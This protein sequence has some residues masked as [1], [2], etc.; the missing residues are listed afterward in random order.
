MGATEGGD[1]FAAKHATENLDREKEPSVFRPDPSTAIGCQSARGHDAVDVRMPDER[2]SPR[3][4]DGQKPDGR[5]EM[6]RIGGHFQ[7]RCGADAEQQGVQQR[8]VPS[9]QRIERV[10]RRQR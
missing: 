4:Q 10:R 1:I 5:A 8:S 6:S 3:V 7:Q 9:T 2:L